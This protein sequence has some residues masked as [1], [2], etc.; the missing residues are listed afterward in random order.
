[1]AS[2]GPSS[3]STTRTR[4]PDIADTFGPITAGSADLGVLPAEDQAAAVGLDD[5]L[6]HA[7]PD[8]QEPVRGD[9]EGAEE[10]LPLERGEGRGAA[11]DR[12][13]DGVG[14]VGVGDHVDDDASVGGDAVEQEP[15]EV[16]ERL[17]ELVTVGL[18]GQ[19][20]FRRG[21]HGGEV[22]APL[23]GLEQE[24]GPLGRAR[25]SL[26]PEGDVGEGLVQKLA[27]VTEVE[28]V[29]PVAGQDDQ[30][31]HQRD[32][33]LGVLADDAQELRDVILADFHEGLAFLFR[34]VRHAAKPGQLG[35]HRHR[36]PHRPEESCRHVVRRAVLRA[37]AVLKDLR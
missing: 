19:V 12:E 16:S 7:G 17:P 18:D 22:V 24:E 15:E 32:E 9:G 23:G 30:L 13:P 36:E 14:A 3:S 10:L 35:A 8:V 33:A 20:R 6:A 27:E 1:M 25:G 11:D 29:L 28:L 4:G 2:R 5:L 21:E 37:A 31:V 26:E 34:R